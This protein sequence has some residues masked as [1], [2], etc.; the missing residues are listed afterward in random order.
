MEY[1]REFLTGTMTVLLLSLLSER[2]MYG[3]EILLEATRRSARAFQMKEGT[4]YPALHKLERGGF[5]KS[6][7]K[8]SA[9]GRSRKYY[10]LT[11]KGRR[12]ARSKRLQW[13]S[14]SSALRAI[15]SST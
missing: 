8:E 2:P 15:W 9:V 10:N 11:S 13:E 1:D 12:T 5:L 3:Y 4:L 14:I 7:W 6:E